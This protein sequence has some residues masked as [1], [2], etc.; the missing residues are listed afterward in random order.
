MCWS[1]MMISIGTDFYWSSKIDS[2]DSIT[3]MHFRTGITNLNKIDISPALHPV[4]Q[5]CRTSKSINTGK[6][7][8]RLIE[9]GNKNF[10]LVIAQT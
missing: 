10:H 9:L 6:L 2:R 8:L 4:Q 3:R 7:F 5:L 1:A